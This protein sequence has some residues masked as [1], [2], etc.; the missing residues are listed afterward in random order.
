MLNISGKSLLSLR[1]RKVVKNRANSEPRSS[2]NSVTNFTSSSPQTSVPNV[3]LPNV[4][5]SHESPRCSKLFANTT[6][7]SNPFNTTDFV[8]TTAHVQSNTTTSNSI[9]AQPVN[10]LLFQLNQMYALQIIFR[11]IFMKARVS[12]IILAILC[13]NLNWRVAF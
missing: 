13:N 6:S 11:Q 1:N 8:N 7:I 10:K 4:K 3:K 9:I 12:V 2:S 5:L